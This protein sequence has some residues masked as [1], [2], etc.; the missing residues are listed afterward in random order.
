METIGWRIVAITAIAPAAW[1][2]TYIVTSELLPP[3][4]PLFAATMRALPAGLILLA[5]RRR[6]PTGDWWWRSIVLGVCNIGLFFPLIFLSAYRLPGGLASTIQATSPLVVMGVAWLLLSERPGAARIT[7]ALVGLL[8]VTL[9]VLRSPGQLDPLGVLAAFSSVAVSA[10][11]FVLIKR[12]SAPVDLVT[13]VSWQLIVGGLLLLPLGLLIEGP[14]PALDL[15]AAAGLL[16]IGGA[17]TI[18]AYI[19]WFHGLRSMPAGAVA[20]VGLLNPVVGTVLGILI[21][22]EVFGLAQA[23]GV[24]LVLGGVLGGQPAVAQA[25]RRWRTRGPTEGLGETADPDEPRRPTDLDDVTAP[26]SGDAP[27]HPLLLR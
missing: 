20:L 6:L 24:A 8:G 27:D 7:A 13:L 2:T 4:R 1:G 16:W 14:P 21:A 25:V 22:A 12:W 19:C 15:G 5:W 3:D 23:L 10:L 26:P 17:G 18:L 11:G 9:L